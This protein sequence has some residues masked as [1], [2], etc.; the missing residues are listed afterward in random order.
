MSQQPST[1]V[2]KTRKRTLQDKKNDTTVKKSRV[3]N[4]ETAVLQSQVSVVSTQVDL[5]SKEEDRTKPENKRDSTEH[6]VI[7]ITESIKKFW[8]YPGKKCEIFVRFL[9]FVKK[10]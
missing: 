6:E 3:D 4:N 1:S 2:A 10:L 5:M 8:K 7:Q 9:H